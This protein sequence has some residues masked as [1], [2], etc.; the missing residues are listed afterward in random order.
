MEE[1]ILI[2]NKYILCP[3]N[4][5]APMI[6]GVYWKKA[7][8]KGAAVGALAGIASWVLFKIF[9]PT[10]YPHNLFGFAVSCIVLII[11]SLLTRK[12]DTIRIKA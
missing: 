11:V 4:Y 2:F 12:S 9:T 10:D 3:R 6:A 5:L 7:N 1:I 8:T